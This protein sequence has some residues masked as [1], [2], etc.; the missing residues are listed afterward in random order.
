M[1]LG[2]LAL[3][4]RECP[5]RG[6][7]FKLQGFYIAGNDVMNKKFLMIL[8]NLFQYFNYLFF[9]DIDINPFRTETIEN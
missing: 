3:V 8:H 7:I 9:F 5:P 4:T 6:G 1:K 2:G